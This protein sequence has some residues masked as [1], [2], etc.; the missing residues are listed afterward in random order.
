MCEPCHSINQ[1]P[2]DPDLNPRVQTAFEKV[3]GWAKKVG[4]WFHF[5]KMG[6]GHSGAIEYNQLHDRWIPEPTRY[7]VEWWHR[8]FKRDGSFNHQGREYGHWGTAIPPDLVPIAEDAE[9]SA[10]IYAEQ[11]SYGSLQIF[12]RF[13]ETSV[14]KSN[15]PYAYF[16]SFMSMLNSNGQNL[17]LEKT[18]RALGVSMYNIN[19]IQRREPI[20][21]M[22][23]GLTR[24]REL[25]IPEWADDTKLWLPS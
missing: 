25:L 3:A 11:V 19:T 16:H 22:C 7:E 9:D 10:R 14:M 6:M 4:S 13:F 1:F 18:R 17:L 5:S 21:K 8:H 12:R 15:R 2:D 20:M 24:K 23:L